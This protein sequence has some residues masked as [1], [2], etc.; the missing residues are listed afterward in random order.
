MSFSV[1][2]LP[3]PLRP[4]RATDSPWAIV[5][6]TSSRALNVSDNSPLRPLTVQTTYSLIDRVWRSVK[7]LST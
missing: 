1:V 2:D 3:E 7:T 4:R 5:N 6:E